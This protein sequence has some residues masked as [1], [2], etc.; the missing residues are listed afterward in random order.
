MKTQAKY[1]GIEQYKYKLFFCQ[2]ATAYVH[3]EKPDE[4]MRISPHKALAVFDPDF[5][6]RLDPGL[7]KDSFRTKIRTEMGL[8]VKDRCIF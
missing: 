1:F 2:R 7:E 8:S 4:R 5:L 3:Q 6:S